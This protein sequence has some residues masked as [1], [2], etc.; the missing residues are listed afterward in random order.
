MSFVIPGKFVFLHM[1]R[2][3]GTWITKQLA[4]ACPDMQSIGPVHMGH[5]DIPKQW[6]HLPV[7]S[8]V[9]DPV[10][11]IESHFSQRAHIEGWHPE[12]CTTDRCQAPTVG[13]F[14]NRLMAAHPALMSQHAA[15]YADSADYVLRFESLAAE[16]THLLNRRGITVDPAKVV[17][18]SPRRSSLSSD[19]ADAWRCDNADYCERYGYPLPD[20][21]VYSLGDWSG[22]WAATAQLCLAPRLRGRPVDLLEVGVCEGRGASVA[23]EWLLQHP[24]STYIGIDNW[25]MSPEYRAERNIALISKG[26]HNLG[27]PHPDWAYDVI[28]IDADHSEA[29]CATDLSA[30]WPRVRLGGYMV[31]DDYGNEQWASEYPGVRVAVDRFLQDHHGELDIIQ[32]GYQVVVQK[33]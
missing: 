22:H 14:A 13:Q 5:A 18:P 12:T 20:G 26:R 10:D 25:S 16:W 29:A 23:F 7:V 1:P 19:V 4:E 32:H 8:V 6:R 21:P 27:T 9:R 28:Y 33:V 15:A 31:V 3:A 24:E 11:W 2:T 30:W 17:N